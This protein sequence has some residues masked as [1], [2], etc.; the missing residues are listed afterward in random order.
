HLITALGDE[1]PPAKAPPDYVKQTFDDYAET[2]DQSLVE[3]L[4]YRTP[5]L[6]A[7]SLEKY[8]PAAEAQLD[9]ADLGCGTGLMGQ[10][11]EPW[12]NSICGVDLS[13]QMM[14][15][16]L[17]TGLYNEIHVAEINDWLTA[18]NRQFDLVLAADVFVYFGDLR[19]VFAL[20]KPRL[21]NGALFAFSVESS[22]N[23]GYDLTVTGRYAH[24][25]DYINSMLA[26]SGLKILCMEAASLRLE[27]GKPV[28][29]LIVV[30]ENSS[31][32]RL[33]G[34]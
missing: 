19:D 16:A 4:D 30:V 8:L 23:P 5:Q 11:I 34:L 13:N 26:Q 14:S 2:F 6:I 20:V 10:A 25:K 7:R 9:I 21:A 32:A 31:S 17:L 15:K 22:D 1:Q 18:D 28:S 29:G 27:Y 33:P 24:H 12:V 3:D